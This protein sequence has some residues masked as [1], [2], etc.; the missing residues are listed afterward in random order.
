MDRKIFNRLASGSKFANEKDKKVIELFNSAKSLDD[1]VHEFEQNDN[2]ADDLDFFGYDA[3]Q[4]QPKE[5]SNLKKSNENK[6]NP[7]SDSEEDNSNSYSDDDSSSNNISEEMSVEDNSEEKDSNEVSSD[8]HSSNSDENSSGDDDNSSDSDD[9]SET[10]NSLFKNQ[11]NQ[12]S[13]KE[14][15]K[16]KIEN[17]EEFLLHNEKELASFR[18][19][20]KIRVNGGD[21]PVPITSFNGMKYKPEQ[22]H[23]KQ[24]V[25]KN[26]EKAVYKEPTPIQMQ[27]IPCIYVGRDV[28]AT[29]P[30][31]SGKTA[32]YLLP[33][34]PRLNGAS[35]DGVRVVI[36]SPS[37]ELC[38]Q[39]QR[40]WIK[41]TEGRKFKCIVLTKSTIAGYINNKVN[42]DI[43]IS[44]PL[45]FVETVK[46]HNLSIK[47]LETIIFDEADKLFEDNFIEQLD[48]V[49]TVC[50][51]P[52]LQR[53]MFSAT[54]PE[55][56]EHLARTILHDPIRIC[57]DI[58]NKTNDNV[59]QELVF[60]GKEEGKLIALR[61]L[62]QQGIDPPVIIFVQS[63]ERAQ[64]LYHELVYD[65][66][67]IDVLHS[68]RPVQTREIVINKFRLRE[69]W[70]LICT[71]L[72]ARGIDF[73]GVNLVI[74]YDFPQ[75]GIS[76]IHRIGRTGR[77]GKKGRAITYFT[78]DDYPMLRSIAN[79]MRISGCDVPEWMLQLKKMDRND[80]KRLAKGAIVRQDIGTISSYDKKRV[81]HKKQ[82]IRDSKQKKFQRNIKK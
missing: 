2:L 52:H 9:L 7:E 71:D 13:K 75:S 70:V 63:K 22:Q 24:I 50:D 27:G 17:E 67:N 37:H 55:G 41:L 59:Q 33:L 30:T 40:E 56:I 68:D 62:F 64:Q 42:V 80:R 77:A 51:N 12:N 47:S 28:L 34:I 61:Q 38:C 49:F 58:N 32:A 39:I 60:A 1:Q 31:G 66:I 11:K 48:A 82:M 23:L 20:M 10:E 16:K 15:E 4:K 26:I 19:R 79:V 14:N 5:K 43:I 73:K 46:E 29:A 81:A 6:Q 69:I 57:I 53:L 76:Y 3:N 8:I 35:K 54:L 45:R 21:I 44:T 74:N 18:G 78:E 36:I 72:V 65:G 25:L